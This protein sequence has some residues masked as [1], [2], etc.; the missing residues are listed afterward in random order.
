MWKICIFLSHFLKFIY[1]LL[2]ELSLTG[3]QN[4][5]FEIIC[6]N[7]NSFLFTIHELSLAKYGENFDYFL[8]LF[9]IHSKTVYKYICS[10]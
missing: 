6:K 4:I 10:K 5:K 1:Q 3:M 8:H 9:F 2:C 7:L